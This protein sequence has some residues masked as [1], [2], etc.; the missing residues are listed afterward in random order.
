[1]D[2]S[3]DLIDRRSFCQSAA[4]GAAGM[5]L[6]RAAFGDSIKGGSR[7][8]L[9]YIL[10]DDLGWGDID[11]Y[12]PH[13]AVPTPHCNEFA[14]QGMRFT[15][16]HAASAV[17]TPSRYGILTGRY[18]WRSRLKKGVLWGE[19]PNLIEPGRMTVP[20]GYALNQSEFPHPTVQTAEYPSHVRSLFF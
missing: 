4:L 1:M 5:L 8:N 10:A 15:D 12:N 13:P 16:M 6:R 20:S 9:I 11:V 2:S 18:P 14:K 17:Y 3:I 19:S 7:P